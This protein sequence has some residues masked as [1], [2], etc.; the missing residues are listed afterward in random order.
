MIH[1]VSIS[2][3]DPKHVADVLAELMKG[4]AY[5][6][7][8]GV[9]NSFMAVSGDEHGSMIE[10]YPETV[11]LLPGQ[12]DGQVRAAI[13]TQR[14]VTGRST[15][16]LGAGRSCDG[17][18]HRRTRGLAHALFRPRRAGSA[19]GVPCHRVLGGEPADDRGRHAGH[20][21]GV[22]ADDPLRSPGRAFRR[23]GGGVAC[24]G[25]L[26]PLRG[27]G[28]PFIVPPGAPAPSQRG[29]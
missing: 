20:A 2:A 4:R 6:F 25:A 16:A 3:R 1:H 9:A 17:R 14:R 15:A 26:H 10:V 28:A 11:A 21:G 7:P 22:Y 19:A 13:T 8:G 24:D 12:D 5:P 27:R 23:P 29:W 18:A